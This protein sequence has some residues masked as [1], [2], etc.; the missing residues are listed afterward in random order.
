MNLEEHVNRFGLEDL[1]E[2]N[3]EWES[4]HE[5]Q[6]LNPIVRHPIHYGLDDTQHSYT[7]G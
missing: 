3:F 2:R 1:S 4:W 6:V 5:E 7:R